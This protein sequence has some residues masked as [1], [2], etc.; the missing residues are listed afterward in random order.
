MFA[1]IAAALLTNPA[2]YKPL[3]DQVDQKRMQATIEKLASWHDRNT[4]NQTLFEAADWI[5]GEFEKIPG[6]KVELFKYQIHKGQRIP[7]DKEV[8]E[9]VATLP[10]KTDRRVIVGG[11][12]DSINMQTPD[13]VSGR[14]PGANDDGSG[15]ALT[16]E[17]ARILSQRQWNQ[18][19]MFVAFSGEEQGLLGSKALAQ[20][21]KAENW[22]IDAVQSNDMVGS[23]S[24]LEGEHDD[25]VIRVFSE[26]L[27]THQ[28]RECAR[29]IELIAR[30]AGIKAGRKPFGV[31]LVFRKDRFGRGGD[32]SSFNDQ[33]F[34]AVR[35]VEPHEEYKHQHTPDDLP[36]FEDWKYLA[37][38]ARVNLAS[39]ATLASADE[40]PTAVRIDRRQGYDTR[41]HWTGKSGVNYVVYWRE[42]TSPV[43]QGW[44]EVG[45]VAEATIQKVSKDDYVFAVGAAGGI[46]VEAK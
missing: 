20:L 27:D 12:F 37:N 23:S 19:L 40:Q 39:M 22:K 44:R 10:G 45:A 46:P 15:V 32:H 3:I 9:V 7:A 25:S 26:D 36:Q 16:L 17:L 41:V 4:S 33:G 31:K 14:A 38:V 43:W 18:T 1:M 29:F 42:T 21:A 28:S 8:V 5:K 24:N 6:L 34:T 2:D 13:M 30:Q 35:F 11:H